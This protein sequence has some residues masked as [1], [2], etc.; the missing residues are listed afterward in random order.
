M[1][2]APEQ[3]G[4]GNVEAGQQ[5]IMILIGSMDVGG[6]ETHLSRILPSLNT[7]ERRLRVVCFRNGGVL[8]GK[9]REQG[10]EVIVP[11][12]QLKLFGLKALKKLLNLFYSVVLVVCEIRRFKPDVAHYFLPEAYMLG[13]FLSFCIGPKRRVM[14]RRSRNFY[15]QRKPLL[16]LEK[17]L[18]RHMDIILTNSTAGL[19][20]LKNEGVPKNKIVLSYNGIDAS[21]FDCTNSD[22][23][24][25]ADL[26][27][28]QDDFIITCVANLIPYKGHTDIVS[29]LK[30]VKNQ[31]TEMALK[32]PQM[33]FVGDDRGIQSELEKQ[34]A[35][36]GVADLLKFS[37][38]RAD[39]PQIL[40]ASDMAV[41]ASHEEGMSNALL[42]Y[43]CC[44]LPI[45]ATDVGGNRE[46]LGDAGML[47]APQSPKD[48]AAAIFEL[49][50]NED[51]AGELGRRAKARVVSH[52]SLSAAIHTY[53]DIYDDLRT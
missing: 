15:H 43:M 10:V 17:F 51:A 11:N 29:A 50:T 52:F 16:R 20:D 36:A 26:A 9:L 35:E 4:G 24:Q 44:A 42:E 14:S 2:N 21:E 7:A 27:M 12:F 31:V 28:Q 3:A 5:K 32:P 49:Y 53:G 8:A 37:G 47:V 22:R 34:A 23:S 19:M 13:G 6:T 46:L 41:L 18:H 38:P 48:L 33:L 45:I 30:L 40:A 39:I 1:E 25:L